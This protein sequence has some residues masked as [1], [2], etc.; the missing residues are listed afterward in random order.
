MRGVS[1]VS[2]WQSIHMT[3]LTTLHGESIFNHGVFPLPRIEK[4]AF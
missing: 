4:S 1:F 3:L 2:S